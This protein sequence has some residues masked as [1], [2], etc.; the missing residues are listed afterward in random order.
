MKK[1]LMSIFVSTILGACNS[2]APGT[3]TILNEVSEEKPSTTN[4]PHIY[5]DSFAPIPKVATSSSY[6]IRLHNDDLSD[7]RIISASLIPLANGTSN[8]KP[9]ARLDKNNCDVLTKHSQCGFILNYPANNTASYALNVVVEDNNHKQQTIRT[10]L[11]SEQNKSGASGINYSFLN[12]VNSHDGVYHL[13]VPVYFSKD[14]NKVGV[15]N[16]NLY[17]PNGYHTGSS[18][19]YYKDGEVSRDELLTTRLNAVKTDGSEVI[20]NGK[21]LISKNL[22]PFLLMSVPQDV[23]I[24]SGNPAAKSIITIAN[25]GNAAATAINIDHSKLAPGVSFLPASCGTELPANDSCN[26]EIDYSNVTVNNSNILEVSY[27]RNGT[28]KTLVHQFIHIINKDEPVLKWENPKT[29]AFENMIIGD[30]HEEE[31][32]LKAENIQF[33]AINLTH[34]SNNDFTI[35]S[36]A[37]GLCK[38]SQI[39]TDANGQQSCQFKVRYTPKSKTDPNKFHITATG[40]YTDANGNQRS[41]AYPLVLTYSAPFTASSIVNIN[42]GNKIELKTISGEP[43]DFVIEVRN[44]SNK[45]KVKLDNPVFSPS[46]PNTTIVRNNCQE[47]IDVCQLVVNYNPP[48]EQATTTSKLGFKVIDLNGADISATNQIAENIVEY[49]AASP[50]KPN[51]V[52]R[53]DNAIGSQTQ[54]TSGYWLE[55]NKHITFNYKITNSTNG[56]AKNIS[57]IANNGWNIDNDN[58]NSKELYNGDSCELKISNNYSGIGQQELKEQDITISYQY[59]KGTDSDN[60]KLGNDKRTINIYE[61]PKLITV[62]GSI[63][64]VEKV[65]PGSS[66]TTVFRIDGGYPGMPAYEIDAT[67]S[68]PGGSNEPLWL[69]WDN[70]GNQC[71]LSYEN[72]RCIIITDS[73]PRASGKTRIVTF[74]NSQLKF[75]EDQLTLV[76]NDFSIVTDN[77]Q[78]MFTP[79]KAEDGEEDCVIDELTG[80]MWP[81]NGNAIQVN[82][83][84]RAGVELKKLNEDELCGHGDWF[85][86]NINE[87]RSLASYRQR[88]FPAWLASNDGPI[89]A[90]QGYGRFDYISST[91]NEDK[92]ITKA[93]TFSVNNKVP[94]IS[95]MGGAQQ[96]LMPARKAKN[97]LVEIWDTGQTDSFGLDFSDG[98]NKRGKQRPAKHLET[99]DKYPDCL[100]DNTTG[101]IWLKEPINKTKYSEVLIKIS[102]MNDSVICGRS[103]WHVPGFGEYISLKEYS[104]PE[105]SLLD[106]MVSSGF[107]APSNPFFFITSTVVDEG[108]GRLSLLQLR[109]DRL[110]IQNITATINEA[111]IVVPSGDRVVDLFLVAG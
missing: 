81:K 24:T 50:A 99:M 16:G 88:D 76:F 62:S 70:N 6:I 89:I 87:L 73:D 42:N 63:G 44:N 59:G 40:S 45:H 47:L 52:A 68:V 18:C 105:V 71:K 35:V 97:G 100:T 102:E 96:F 4:N 8:N 41:I 93:Y 54:D 55:K 111:G 28:K 22:T 104:K 49:A 94:Q 92:P 39:I 37:S 1:V 21:S 109:L 84:S 79:G 23:E 19:T 9:Q 48:T 11:L 46:I 90:N 51:L 72:N 69:E 17:C 7:Y 15:N 2:A 98:A 56:V 33:D 53:L 13:A 61:M 57:V 10:V 29:N 36:D 3:K 64:L 106:Y 82:S 20:A 67:G 38:A 34:D 31:F 30:E 80:L 85:I 110:V 14:F 60:I 12:T 83:L 66:F 43:K 5:F 103:D 74:T 58:C 77:R 107:K 26:I 95:I 86:P 27:T 91:V 65:F 101:K 32:V 75:T 108:N 78:P 25:I